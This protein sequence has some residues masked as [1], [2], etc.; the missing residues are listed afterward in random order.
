MKKAVGLSVFLLSMLSI[1]PRAFAADNWIQCDGNVVTIG[2]AGGKEETKPVHDVFVIDDAAQQ[3]F[4]YSDSRKAL[5]LVFVTGYSPKQITWG[6]PAGASYG[7]AR[8]EGRLDRATQALSLVRRQQGETMTWTETC[9]P[10]QPL[11]K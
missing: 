3:L 2:G 5:D 9:K 11:L 1:L 4:R 6:S 10:T 7:D 8:W